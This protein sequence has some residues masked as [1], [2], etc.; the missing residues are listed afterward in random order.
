MSPLSLSLSNLIVGETWLENMTWSMGCKFIW[1]FFLA[2]IF[3]LFSLI[4]L[5]M[6]KGGLT[7]YSKMNG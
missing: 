4:K 5:S 6:L 7:N 3:S 2:H 1:F